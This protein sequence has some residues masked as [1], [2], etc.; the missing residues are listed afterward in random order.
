LNALVGDNGIV[1][2]TMQATEKINN[3][4]LQEQ[5]EMAVVNIEA[6]YKEDNS[7]DKIS[8]YSDKDAFCSNGSIDKDTYDITNYSLIESMAKLDIKCNENEYTF[9]IDVLSG[10]VQECEKTVCEIGDYVNYPV[11]YTNII[12]SA[13]RFGIQ[14][15]LN[16]WRV[17]ETDINGKPTK[18]ISAGVPISYSTG[19]S[20]SLTYNNL[21]TNFKTTNFNGTLGSYF[22]N[23]NYANN[24]RSITF[25]EVANILGIEY[26]EGDNW[27]RKFLSNGSSAFEN[28]ND[29]KANILECMSDYFIASDF[30]HSSTSTSGMYYYY[31]MGKQVYYSGDNHPSGVKVVVELNDD[32]EVYKS[33]NNDGS[34][35]DNAYY[36]FY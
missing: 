31:S 17:I 2:K 4:S 15:N 23:E 22:L 10:S 35:K 26:F 19:S 34:S 29:K 21:I 13:L 24:V 9:I 30:T 36:L 27:L 6:I 11:E 12:P 18:I 7:I 5:L 14:E 32:I 3:A 20:H 33:F 28:Y 16:G 1:N 8:L 25:N